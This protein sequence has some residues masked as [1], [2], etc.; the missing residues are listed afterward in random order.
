MERKI[1]KL[2]GLNVDSF[3]FDDAISYANSISGQV[4]TINPEMISSAKMNSQ[5]IE[6]I[7]QAELVIPDGI[8]VEIGLKVLGHRVK[9][10]AGIEFAFSIMREFANRN[11]T[12]AL[13]GAS[14]DTVSKAVINLKS[15]I[16]DLNLVYVQ[17]GYFTDEGLVIKDLVEV[18]PSLLL[19]AL[20]SP[21]Q[22]EIIYKL[23]KLMPNTLMIGVGGSFDVWAGNV[24]R[25]P[26]IYQKLGLEWLY[27]TIMQP[28]RFK[29]IF[30]TLPLFMLNVI[31]E[32]MLRKDYAC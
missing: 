16:K 20:G 11:R 32:K 15:Q 23:K 5:L 2:Q 25:A 29:R 8:G 22:E 27:R 14:E 7:Q 31:K 18:S 1:F 24:L 28:S 10:I 26:E 12:V 4:V 30:P 13:L 3:D 6:I 21:K 19:V 9:R 17:N